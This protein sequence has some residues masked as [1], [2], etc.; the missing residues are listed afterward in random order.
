MTRSYLSD[1]NR[2]YY[3]MR[4]DVRLLPFLA[5]AIK[6]SVAEAVDGDVFTTEKPGCRSVL[7][8]GI[9]RVVQPVVQVVTPLHLFQ[10][11]A[12]RILYL[13]LTRSLPLI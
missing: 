9:L 2:K 7:E 10:Y 12:A 13:I 6:S 3:H 8:S 11:F 4:F 1:I 5:I